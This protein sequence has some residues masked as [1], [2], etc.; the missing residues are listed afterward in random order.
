VAKYTLEIPG[1]AALAYI[2]DP[3]STLRL[4]EEITLNFERM[5]VR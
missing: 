4:Q 5:D 1:G 2:N 3:T